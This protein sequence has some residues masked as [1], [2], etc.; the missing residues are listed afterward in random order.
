MSR[1]RKIE[2]TANHRSTSIHPYAQRLYPA[3]KE[4]ITILALWLVFP[5][6]GAVIMD[7]PYVAITLTTRAKKL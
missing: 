3:E 1:E 7:V 4:E 2:H 5:N 6:E